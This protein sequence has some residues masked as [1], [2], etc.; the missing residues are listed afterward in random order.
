MQLSTQGFADGFLNGFRTMADY[1]NQQKA[2][3]RAD[4]SMNLQEQEYKDGKEYRDKSWNHMVDREGVLDGRY[5][6]E[7]GYNR[8]RQGEIDDLNKKQTMASIANDGARTSATV[9]Q[10][11]AAV[12]LSHQQL[13]TEKLQYT[14]T[15]KQLWAAENNGLLVGA[16]KNISAG[17]PVTEQQAAALNDPRAGAMNINK[18][19]DQNFVSSAAGL[20]TSVGNIM[21]NYKPDQFHSQEFYNQLNSPEIKQQMDVVFH[22]EINSGLGNVDDSGKKVVSKK[23]AGIV[24]MKDGSLALEVTPVYEDGT[25]GEPKPVTVNRSS[26]KNDLVRTFAPADIVGVI[27]ARANLANSVKNPSTLMQDIG[28][29][30]GP[31]PKG[32]A[33]SVAD[34]DADTQKDIQQI[35]RN[36]AGSSASKDEIEKQIQDSRAAGESRKTEYKKLYGMGDVA[37]PTPD[38]SATKQKAVTEWV[39][40]DQGKQAYYRALMQTGR[41]SNEMLTPELLESGYQ[42][43]LKDQKYKTL[44]SAILNSSPANKNQQIYNSPM[45]PQNK[46]PQNNNDSSMSSLFR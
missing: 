32:Y 19:A 44:E 23:Y 8:K 7:L 29:V 26:D 39:G 42:S 12:D 36:A 15:Q 33:K 9:A 37:S 24:P 3:D 16:W 46:Q 25:S 6:E 11:K 28:V 14:T 41:Y 5:T 27:N 17:Q 38:P 22:D 31:D 20:K 21:A 1:Q 4:R 2:S 13:Q 40:G 45:Q 43:V 18:Y 35:R 30:Q 10:S 34:I